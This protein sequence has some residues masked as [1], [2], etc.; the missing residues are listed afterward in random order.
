MGAGVARSRKQPSEP[1]SLLPEAVPPVDN[2]LGPTA[3]AGVIATQ[4]RQ[5]L[6]DLDEVGESS[7][8]DV[9][10]PLLE[11]VGLVEE[12]WGIDITGRDRNG[13]YAPEVSL[14]GEGFRQPGHGSLRR[15]VGTLALG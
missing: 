1:E 10:L 9:G 14:H 15:A 5:G 2:Q 3:I 6:G 4:E 13:W 11:L 7:H 12:Q 8:D